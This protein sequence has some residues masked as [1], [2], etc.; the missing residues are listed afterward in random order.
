MSLWHRLL[1]ALGLRKTLS[2]AW[3]REFDRRAFRITGDSSPRWNW[4]A[5][6]KKW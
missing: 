4:D 1:I 6:D 2:E 3:W 5:W